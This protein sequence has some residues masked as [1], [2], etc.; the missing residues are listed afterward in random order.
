MA[1]TAGTMVL[2]GK[3]TK[4]VYT[5]DLYIPDATATK[6]GFNP[7]GLAGTASPTVFRIPEDCEIVDISIGTAP[8]AVGAALTVNSGVVNGGAIRW[9]NQ[10]QT[11]ANRLKMKVPLRAGDFI[12]YTQF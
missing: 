1:A 11:L 10:L 6:L 5:I 8:T 9:A 4:K 2:L 3:N 12:E 7:S